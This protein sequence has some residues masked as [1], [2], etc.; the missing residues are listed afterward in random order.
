MRD[1]E[2][3]YTYLNSKCATT[4]YENAI[5]A[6]DMLLIQCA[7]LIKAQIVVGKVNFELVYATSTRFAELVH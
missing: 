4:L 1:S 2:Y 5:I 6:R 3:M 7:V